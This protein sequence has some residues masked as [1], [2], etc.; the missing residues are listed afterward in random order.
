MAKDL[1]TTDNG[2]VFYN[3]KNNSYIGYS[4]R[5]S[6]EFKIGDMLFT[7]KLSKKAIH[8]VYCDKKLRWKMLKSLLRYHFKNDVF[9]FEDVF[10]DNIIGHGIALYIPFKQ[11]GEKTIETKEEAYRAAC[12][13]AKHVS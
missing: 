6:C 11:K 10:E 1:E 7:G 2:Q 12:N 13:F 5:A 8:R 4:H 3:K 9:S